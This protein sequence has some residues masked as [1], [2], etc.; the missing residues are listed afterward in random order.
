MSHAQFLHGVAS[1]D[2]TA[3]GIV[4]WTRATPDASKPAAEFSTRW[5]LREASSHDQIATGEEVASP[6]QDWTVHVV[7]DG[8]AADTAYE[9]EFAIDGA[10][11]PLGTFRTLPTNASRLSF[12]VFACTK[13]NAGYFNAYRC[14]ATR[15]DLHF[16]V[17][18]GDYVYE[19]SNTPPATQTPGADIGR[20]F[21]PLHECYTLA[22]YRERYA[23]YRGDP[24]AQ[25]LHQSHAFIL[26]LQP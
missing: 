11:S 2:P 12:G 17:G 3:D 5:T 19:A 16:V 9:Y 14:L 21:S 24:D 22:D 8:L 20:D 4:L 23:Q 25:A 18:L 15:S 1:G 13:F 7:A 6:D 26:S 10:V